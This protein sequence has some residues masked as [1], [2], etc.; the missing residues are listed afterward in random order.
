MTTLIGRH[1]VAAALVG[2][3]V[4][5]GVAATVQAGPR[6]RLSR[7]LS[8][9][10]TRG[11]AATRDVIL[12]ADATTVAAVAARHGAQVKKWLATGAVLSVSDANLDGLTTDAAVDHLSGD[13]FVHSMM[14]ITDPAIGEDQVL[15]GLKGIGPITGRGIGIALIDSGVSNHVALKG[16]IAA[17]LD[18]TDPAGR[19]VDELGHGTHVAGII[20]GQD[21]NF[22]GVAPGAWIVSLKVLGADGSGR[23]SDVINA[24]DWATTHARQY[25]I[26]VI[27]LSLGRPVFESYLDDPLCQAVERAYRAGLLV[28]TS[29]GNYGMTQDGQ[30]VLGAITAPGNSPYAFTVGSLDSQNTIT[31]S[32]DVVSDY[33]SRGPTLYDRLVKPDIAAPGRKIVSL[34]NEGSTLAVKYPDH[35]VSGSGRNGLFYLSGTS[36]ATGV[37]SGAAALVLETNPKLTPLQVRVALQMSASFLPDAGLIGAG[38]GE[39]N[40]AAAVKL[41]KTGPSVQRV[42]TVIAGEPVQSAV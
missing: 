39:L 42:S 16:H 27:N 32:D 1:Q 14:A 6:A 3:V 17:A 38:A 29:A 24:I 21:D 13:T 9:A 18:F 26:R 25:G 28:V 15:A 40:V 20:G 23:T 37:V 41:A 34:Y 7:D 19:G 10:L 36:M 5:C 30:K 31:R 12:Q 4:A 2:A 11:G 22:Q 33:S 8:D 35:L